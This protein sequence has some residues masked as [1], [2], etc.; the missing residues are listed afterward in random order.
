MKLL[1]RGLITQKSG[2]LFARSPNK[3]RIM[4]YFCKGNPV[5]SVHGRWTVTSSHGPPWTGGGVDRRVP[6]CGGMLIGA[7]PP[8]TPGHG[9]SLVGEEKREG[10]VGVP[11]HAS[12]RLGRWCGG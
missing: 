8:A 9:S 1:D 12:S 5:D 6:G 10:S 11:S 2:E 3:P 4:N 7:R